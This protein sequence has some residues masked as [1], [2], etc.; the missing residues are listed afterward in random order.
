MGSA[1][2]ASLSLGYLQLATIEEIERG[3]PHANLFS[4]GTQPLRYM[5]LAKGEGGSAG[6]KKG[7]SDAEYN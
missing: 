7:E 4:A 2:R 3:M 5:N 1:S 6:D